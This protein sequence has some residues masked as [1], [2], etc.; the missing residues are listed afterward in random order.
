MGVSRPEQVD[1][2]AVSLSLTLPPEHRAALHAASDGNRAFLYG[3]FDP[4]ARNQ[5]VFGGADVRN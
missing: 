3:L 5:I 2:N 4:A 1:D